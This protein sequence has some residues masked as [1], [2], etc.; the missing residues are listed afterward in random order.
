MLV[1]K[2]AIHWSV[3]HSSFLKQISWY[4]YD[5][6]IGLSWSSGWAAA[7]LKQLV[8][9]EFTVDAPRQYEAL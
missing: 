5:G 3:K 1:K 4:L 6:H 8:L 7:V 9:D 2:S